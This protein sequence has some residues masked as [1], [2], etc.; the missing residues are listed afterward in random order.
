MS[1]S[2]SHNEKADIINKAKST[3][4]LCLDYKALREVHEEK[5][6]TSM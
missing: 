6:V 4:I 3:I 1:V 5:I 2:M